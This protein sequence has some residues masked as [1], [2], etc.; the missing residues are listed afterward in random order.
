[1][2]PHTIKLENVQENT[3]E[4]NIASCASSGIGRKS[5]KVV[6]KPHGNKIQYVVSH[7]LEGAD[8]VVESFT[9][10]KFAVEAYNRIPV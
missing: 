2:N 5:L 10:F 8:E 7:K 1:M 3:V 9:I 6:V 4:Q